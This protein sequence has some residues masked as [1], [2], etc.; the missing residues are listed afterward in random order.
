MAFIGK[1]IL[2]KFVF[3]NILSKTHKFGITTLMFFL[4]LFDRLASSR[5]PIIS[6]G[7]LILCITVFFFQLSLDSYSSRLMILKY[8]VIPSVLFGYQSLPPEL[9]LIHPFVTVVTSMFLHGGWLHIA[10]NMLYLWIF[11][12]N[13]EE[14]MG[15]LKFIIFYIICGA[16]AA[17]A[18]SMIAP[19]SITPMI[20]ASGGIAGILGAYIVLHPKAPVQV[21]IVI[22]IFIRFISLPAWVVLGVWILTQFAAA[23]IAF[24]GESGVA[25]FAHIGGFIAGACLIPFFKRRELPLFGKNDQ[26][27]T[28]TDITTPVSFREVKK[29]AKHK[30]GHRHLVKGK[31]SGS[32]PSFRKPP[33]GPWDL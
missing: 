18:Q 25:Y 23:P 15:H 6:W 22:L 27:V 33:K 17:L 4:P 7:I 1:C 21:L 3:G 8:G 24:S 20:G 30:Y 11:S 2:I 26:A 19:S 13:I 12:D 32:L 31:T 5:T 14:S 28:Q 16:V 29:Q 10:S 9:E